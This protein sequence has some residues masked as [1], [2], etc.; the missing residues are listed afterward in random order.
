MTERG[1]DDMGRRAELVMAKSCNIHG[2]SGP[3]REHV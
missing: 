1:L 2:W 3:V